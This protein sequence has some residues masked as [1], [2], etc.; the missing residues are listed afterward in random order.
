MCYMQLLVCLGSVAAAKMDV[1]W[2]IDCIISY[3]FAY[4]GCVFSSR[5]R[6][7][8]F[9]RGFRPTEKFAP[10]YIVYNGALL[11]SLPGST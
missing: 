5:V 1:N 10:R 3:F 9:K 11:C 7:H 8:F 4:V 6:D 2:K